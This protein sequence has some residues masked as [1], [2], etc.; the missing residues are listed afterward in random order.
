[1]SKPPTSPPSERVV[2][3]ALK[4][5]SKRR[6]PPN[7]YNNPGPCPYKTVPADRKTQAEGFAR[8]RAF[9]QY[10]HNN[11]EYIQADK[12]FNAGI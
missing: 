6:S 9:Q 7:A 2:V 5:S 12:R 11:Y 8:F 1:M 3:F 4:A 10:L